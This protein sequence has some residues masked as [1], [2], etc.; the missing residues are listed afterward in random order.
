[1]CFKKT[2][3]PRTAYGIDIK[4][5]RILREIRNNI[6]TSEQEGAATKNLVVYNWKCNQAGLYAASQAWPF[7]SLLCLGSS[8]KYLNNSI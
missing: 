4:I 1:M 7:L 8:L 6:G 3:I 5:M 2:R